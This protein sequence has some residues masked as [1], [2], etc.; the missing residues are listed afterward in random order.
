LLKRAMKPFIAALLN[1]LFVA[2]TAARR[3][4]LRVSDVEYGLESFHKTFHTRAAAV[5][6]TGTQSE[7][8]FTQRLFEHESQL[9]DGKVQSFAVTLQH[10]I[11]LTNV[12]HAALEDRTG[13]VIDSVVGDDLLMHGTTADADAMRQMAEV[14]KVVALLPELKISPHFDQ[15]LPQN[16]SAVR[17]TIR[18][19]PLER[20]AHLRS[21]AAE[22]GSRLTRTLGVACSSKG[23]VLRGRASC[24]GGSLLRADAESERTLMVEGVKR[25][26]AHEVAALLAAEPE[27]LWLEPV[28]HFFVMNSDA[29]NIVQS[30]SNPTGGGIGSTPIGTTPIWDM[31]IHGEDEIV[32]VA[33]SGLDTGHCFFENA[34]DQTAAQQ[35]YS[36]ASRKVVS[37]RPFADNGA[38]GLRDHGTHVTGSILGESSSTFATGSPAAARAGERGVAYKAR[39]SFTDIGLGDANGLSVPNDLANNMFNVDYNAGARIHSNSWGASINAYTTYSAQV[40]EFSA[41]NDDFVI[42]FAAGN[43]GTE[44]PGSIGAPATAKNCITVGASEN[45]N[46]GGQRRDGNMAVFSSQGPAGPTTAP[47]YKPDVAA[48]GF[49]VTSANSNADGAGECATTE[50]AGTSMATPVTAGAVALVRQYLREGFHPLGVKGAS[51]SR[52]PS[53]ALLKA[54]II[55]SAID[56]Q[57]TYQGQTITPVPSYVQG[58]G[59]IQLNR[60]LFDATGQ[61]TPGDRVLIVDDPLKP[62]ALTNDEHIFEIATA[63]TD[64]ILGQQLKVTLVWTDPP[65]QPFQANVLVNDLDLVVESAGATQL[66]NGQ[67]DVLNNVEQVTLPLPNTAVASHTIKVIGA[68][69]RQGSQ[70]YALVVSGP[71][72]VTSPPPSPPHPPPPKPPAAPYAEAVVLG[73]SVPLLAIALGAGVS[74]VCIKRRRSAAARGRG[75]ALQ[76]AGNSYG[77]IPGWRT[78]N[79]PSSGQ[80]YYVNLQTGAAQWE[81]PET[82][83][84]QANVP[85]PPPPPGQ[86]TLPT[87]WS[88]GVDPGTGRTYFYNANTLQSQWVRP[89]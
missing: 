2:I 66:G 88:Q 22:I 69:V 89:E 26:E 45:S 36:A 58:Y 44:G 10:G 74:F 81:V 7:K 53:G 86:Q 39:V 46:S 20:H 19:I 27:V 41:E 13:V 73:V 33:D 85:P 6:G 21:S 79:D 8:H 84:A 82:A 16:V 49:F 76:G 1:L 32:G 5:F 23:G 68:Q 12:L 62:I 14:R 4:Q 48:P 38:T 60:V 64:A 30:G 47:R 55:N 40:D 9:P 61:K 50:M 37:Y 17:L 78:V 34:P 75:Y 83:K 57:G 24:T 51:P 11:Q 52:T 28:P 56:M 70:K 31:G 63:G 18:L 15:L 43:D 87:G 3:R 59:R 29:V 77:G 54:M 42:L 67:K 35:T 71:L 65:A 25:N 72:Q 80:T